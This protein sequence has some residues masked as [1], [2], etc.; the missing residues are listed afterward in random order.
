MRTLNAG[1]S[2][3]LASNNYAV[4]MRARIVNASGTIV[5]LSNYG[6]RD[7]LVGAEWGAN[8]DE[9]VPSC[10]LYFAR[11]QNST[12]SLAP[13]MSA[14]TLNVNDA[15][16]YAALLDPGAEFYL[17]TAVI[18]QGSTLPASGSTQWLTQFY[19][20]IDAVDFDKPEVQVY[21]RDKIGALLADRWIEAERPY[22]TEGGEA[23]QT[24]MQNISNEWADGTA[25][26]VP[27][28]PGFLV[29]TYQQTQ[30][31]VLEAH[32]TLAQ[33]IG[34]DARPQWYNTS[35]SFAYVF[36]QPNR[37]ASTAVWTFGPQHYF[38][39]TRLNLSRENV[40]NV[41]S[42]K[43]TLSSTAGSTT[44]GTRQTYTASDSTS[45]SRFGRRW[46]E[47]DLPDDSDINT[48]AEATQLGAACLSDLMIPD[49]EQEIE[50]LYF[51]PTQL[52]D[53]Y[54]FSPN[55][56]H[57]D[58]TQEWAVRGYRHRLRQNE[59]RTYLTVRGKPAGQYANWFRRGRII[60]DEVD[61]T[62]AKSLLNFRDSQNSTAGTVTFVWTRGDLVSE[63]WIYDRLYTQPEPASPWPADGDAPT[64]ILTVGTDTY[65]ASVPSSGRIRNIQFEPRTATLEAG[66]I[67]R[68]RLFPR[69]IGSVSSTDIADG[70]IL[71]SK[72]IASA[73]TFGSDIVFTATDNDTVAWTAGTITFAGSTQYSIGASNTGNMASTAL[74]YIY[75]DTGAAT[76]ALQVTTS[77]TGFSGDGKTLMAVAAKAPSTAQSAFFVP[78]VG[79]L[80]LN[81]DNL[82]PSSV[83]TNTIAANTITAAKMNVASL[84]A[85]SADLGTVTAGTISANVINASSRFTAANAEFEGGLMIR[86]VSGS[87]YNTATFSVEGLFGTAVLTLKD[88]TN[89]TGGYIKG[90]GSALF[91]GST[92]S[93]GSLWVG[94]TTGVAVSFYGVTPV[95]RQVVAANTTAIHAALVSL[96]LISS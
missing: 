59:H 87:T 85:I 40:R 10:T 7:W 15:G 93:T 18:A 4:F 90:S 42:V 12:Q 56:V 43:Y 3:V 55:G 91:F 65:Q 19:G 17:D 30:Q 76:T 37:S 25:V 80:G 11:S 66:P 86:G 68:V 39:V 48:L 46:M 20:E 57:Y 82:S 73:Q 38:D 28:S 62:N 63:V 84:S 54:A 71:S 74:R 78:A 94:D 6:G 77:A 51:W 96:G 52:G 1:S 72:L 26:Q 44:A 22:G 50:T 32:R 36:A 60:R 16:A 45:I 75:F 79:I 95:Q 33:L 31:S 2:A 83:T 69:T 14:S 47:I 41:V 89:R 13:L 53:Y 67:R 58:S 35:S 81:G 70:S 21:G 23:I 5:D 92:T 8:I 34:W 24:V 61:L 88:Y 29:T 49:A 9:I 27:A 64:S